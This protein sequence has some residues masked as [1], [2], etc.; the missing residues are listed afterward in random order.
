M[1]ALLLQMLR[2]RQGLHPIRKPLQ[3]SHFIRCVELCVISL[4]RAS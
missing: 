3:F 1:C 2:K 4:L